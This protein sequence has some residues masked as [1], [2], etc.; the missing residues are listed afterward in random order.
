M[1][2]NATPGVP[3]AAPQR[4]GCLTA[5]LIVFGLLSL[6]AAIAN[7]A[8]HNKL[9]SNLPNAPDWAATGVL[10]M[11][12]L[13]LIG[14]AAL[15]ALWFWKKWGLF[16]YLAMGIAVFVLNLKLVGIGPSLLGLV[17]IALVTIF[18]LRQWNDFQ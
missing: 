14:V 5:I 6:L 11:G 3:A 16:V 1:D 18:V 15:A 13:G 8:L 12:F 4:H 9:A 2:N 7:L 17:G 10:A